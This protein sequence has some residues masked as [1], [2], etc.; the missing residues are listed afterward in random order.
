MRVN[1]PV[2]LIGARDWH[3]LVVRF[4][5]AKL[6]L[7]IDGVLVDEEYPIGETRQRTVPFLIGAAHENGQL[8]TGFS[9]LID[10]VAVWNRAL[11]DDEVTALSGGADTVRNANWRCSVP[12]RP[13][14][15]LPRPRA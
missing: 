5:G 9:G 3:D 1:F 6:Q 7:F 8:K 12:K 13:H 10:H 2:G 15:V 4:S 11:T 14:A